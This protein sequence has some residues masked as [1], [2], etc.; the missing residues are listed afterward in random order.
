MK[1]KTVL[2]FLF[3]LICSFCFCSGV[4]EGELRVIYLDVGQGDATLINQGG[5]WMLID[6]GDDNLKASRAISKAISDYGITSFDAIIISHNDSDH[7]GG[8]A[9]VLE[10]V[11]TV[12]KL[13]LS[14]DPRHTDKIPQDKSLKKKYLNKGDSFQLGSAKVSCIGP[15]AIDNST[16]SNDCSLCLR[17]DFGETSFLFM[18][19]AGKEVE[20]ALIKEYEDKDD[21]LKCTVLKVSH[22]GSKES[23]GYLFLQETL[24]D[25]NKSTYAILSVGENNKYNHPSPN[26]ISLFRDLRRVDPLFRFF[27]T[28]MQG[29][30]TVVSDGTNISI[31]AERNRDSADVFRE[32]SQP[33]EI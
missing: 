25:N 10:T 4:N 30:I 22:H 32:A 23:S 15:I 8:L 7:I 33:N 28:D 13:Y 19:D 2:I 3:I 21:M 27:R 16:S 11:S 31:S 18:G 29:T 12:K 26:A 14:N 5:H 24:L 9:K 1:K 20:N 17:I 6:C